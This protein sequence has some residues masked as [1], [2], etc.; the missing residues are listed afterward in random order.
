M[1]VPDPTFDD[2]LSRARNGDEA[3]MEQIARTYESDIR[4]AARVHLGPALRPY[5]DSID[6]V[7]SVHRSLLVGLRNEKFELSNLGSLIAL[8]VKMV[9]RKV[10]HQWRRHR[11]QM[12]L[13][14]TDSADHPADV[15]ASLSR[16]HTNP[17]AAV[18]VREAL[19]RLWQELDA[20]DRRLLELRMQGYTTAETAGEM[21][22]SPEA[23][24][25]RLH[26]LRKRLK[27]EQVLTE[28]L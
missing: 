27:D 8:A 4:I 15:L 6:L 13:T 3:A 20:D 18:E 28:W 9:R 12:R 5:L 2:L 17:A 25:V 11:R 26:R 24:R 23:L 10:A 7:Q 1:S 16:R 14:G 19:N 22:V 21:G